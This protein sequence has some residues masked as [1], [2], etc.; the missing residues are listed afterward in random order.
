MS[1]SNCK[2]DIVAVLKHYV[3]KAVVKYKMHPLLYTTKRRQRYSLAQIFL[4]ESSESLLYVVT[5]T[6]FYYQ[7]LL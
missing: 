1:V 2:S 5:V 4:N 6:C 3:F 7:S